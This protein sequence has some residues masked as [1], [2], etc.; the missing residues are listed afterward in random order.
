MTT[1]G[2]R[3]R[4]TLSD[5]LKCWK[6]PALRGRISKCP[7]VRGKMSTHLPRSA[8]NC[9][10]HDPAGKNLDPG[11]A[12]Q[13]PFFARGFFLRARFPCGFFTRTFLRTRY[14]AH[15]FLRTRFC[16]VVCAR[17]ALCA[18]FCGTLVF[19]R[20]SFCV[21]VFARAFLRVSPRAFLSARFLC[22]LFLRLG[23][24][25]GAFCARGFFCLRVLGAHVFARAFFCVHVSMRARFARAFF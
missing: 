16:A 25:A 18:R 8:K 20:A 12:G 13:M 22:A 7:V 1:P 5:P 10:I 15:V 4:Q 14:F 2:S 19:S 23:F 21:R 11:P 24:S 9:K 6:I 3:T 17:A